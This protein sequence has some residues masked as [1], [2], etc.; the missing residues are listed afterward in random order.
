MSFMV[1]VKEV[2]QESLHVKIFKLSRTDGLS[3]PRFSAGSHITTYVS[4]NN[5]RLE[6]HYSLI[7]PPSNTDF[8]QIAVR[9]SD[10][11]A[12]GSS[13]WHHQIKEGDFIEI[14][15]PKNQ[16]P[17]SFSAKHHVFIAAGIG[18]TPFLAMAAYLKEKGKSFEIHYAAKSKELCAFYSYLQTHYPNT[19]Y[20]YFS[21][22]QKMKPS[23]LE[24]KSIGTHVYVCGS[25]EMMKEYVQAASEYGYPNF[26]IHCELFTPPK[27]GP[28]QAFNVQLKKRN[29]EIHVPEGVSLLDALISH[30][31]DAPYS[32]KIGGCGSCQVDVIKGE[33]DHRDVFLS[34]EERKNV[35]VILT[36]VSRAKCGTLVLDL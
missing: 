11:S 12:G 29:K 6:R 9:L 4:T 26:N 16:F 3:L 8:Y 7:S 28:M 23:L 33:I 18:I 27:Q 31:I 30:N 19:T 25:E 20:F 21:N 32:C 10:Q 24:G 36:C 5:K 35:N 2:K 14:G 1:M 34:D 15:Y 13:Y 22:I 17:L